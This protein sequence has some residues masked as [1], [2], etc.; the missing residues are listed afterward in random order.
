MI[1]GEIYF[2]GYRW[3]L[4][5]PTGFTTCP[6][7]RHHAG[8]RPT[9]A[10]GPTCGHVRCLLIPGLVN[11]S[12][13]SLVW[14]QTQNTY[15]M[16]LTLMPI[17]K[18]CVGLD[19]NET[20]IKFLL[21]QRFCSR[22]QPATW[23]SSPSHGWPLLTLWQTRDASRP[24]CLQAGESSERADGLG[25][26]A[27]GPHWCQVIDTMDTTVS[28]ALSWRPFSRVSVFSDKLMN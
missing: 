10:K 7:W 6:L 24:V 11:S 3:L 26:M 22:P 17:D 27:S 20:K 21:L 1:A 13:V 12:S 2:V 16:S 23:L 25:N 4:G 15:T 9:V 5:W 8:R 28:S 19:F 18:E 14:Q